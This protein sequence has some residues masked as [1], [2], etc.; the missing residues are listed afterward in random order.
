MASLDLLIPPLSPWLQLRNL[1]LKLFNDRNNLL[2]RKSFVDVL[3]A[4]DVPRFDLKQNHPFD[5]ARVGR[6]SRSLST[7][8]IVFQQHELCPR[9]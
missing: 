2:L 6:E 7:H 9:A 3:R 1:R 8:R 5:L 4:V